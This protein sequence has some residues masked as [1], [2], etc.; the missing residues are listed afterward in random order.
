MRK[1]WNDAWWSNPCPQENLVSE[2]SLPD[3]LEIK[4][5]LVWAVRERN[6]CLF[7]E[8]GHMGRWVQEWENQKTWVNTL[9]H[10]R[11]LKV[12]PWKEVTTNTPAKNFTWIIC[13][14]N[15]SWMWTTG[16]LWYLCILAMTYLTDVFEC[17]RIRYETLLTI[18]TERKRH[19][20]ST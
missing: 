7:G 19:A 3:H 12:L 16:G 6:P 5:T 1:I 2:L 11:L 14:L 15:K 9:S 20:E 10:H 18:P 13:A 4:E 8:M 17:I